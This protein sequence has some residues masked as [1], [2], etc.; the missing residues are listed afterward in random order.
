MEAQQGPT[1]K[2]KLRVLCIHG[3]RQNVDVF[4]DKTL[5]NFRFGPLVQVSGLQIHLVFVLT[6]FC[7]TVMP[8]NVA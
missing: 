8:A 4:R 6:S 3:Y 2:K 5:K 1:T 7:T